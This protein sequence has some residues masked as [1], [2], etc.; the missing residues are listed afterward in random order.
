MKWWLS[1]L[2]IA[3]CGQVWG[4]P[5]WH[6]SKNSVE[7]PEQENIQQEAMFSIA[8]LGGRSDVIG[9]S[10]RDLIDV[11]SGQ[12]VR[13]GGRPL[14]ACFYPSQHPA[15]SSAMK[16]LGIQTGAIQSMAR[17]SSIVQSNLKMVNDEKQ[18]I[19]CIGKNF[20]AV[21]YLLQETDSERVSTC[22]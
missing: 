15:T 9:V 10:L 20:P 2:V 16:S 11:Y 5:L 1:L 3:A 22:F 21:G 7:S 6:C 18:M 14:T 12:P 8:G 19:T 4:E 13:V 17:G